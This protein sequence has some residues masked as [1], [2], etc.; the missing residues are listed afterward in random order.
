MKITTGSYISWSS[1]AG[2]LSGFIKEISLAKNA[3]GDL[4]PWFVVEDVLNIRT[5]VRLNCNVLLCATEQSMAMMKMAIQDG[6]EL[7]YFFGSVDKLAA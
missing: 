4:V 7:N 1:S 6:N 2:T 5:N 3:A